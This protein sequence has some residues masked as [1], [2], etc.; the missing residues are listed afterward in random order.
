[1]TELKIIAYHDEKFKD[2]G[3]IKNGLKTRLASALMNSEEDYSRPNE[4]LSLSLICCF[5]KTIKAIASIRKKDVAGE[6]KVKILCNTLKDEKGFYFKIDL[7][8]GIE[9]LSILETK[10]LMDLTHQKCPVSRM[11]DA[12]SHFILKSV[13]FEEI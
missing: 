7:F 11:F 8:C 10:E 12:Y 13:L 2:L 3:I 1:M 6:I 4:L 5:Y 9:N